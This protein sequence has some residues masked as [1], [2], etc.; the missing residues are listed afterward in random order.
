M[1]LDVWARGL[2]GHAGQ[3]PSLEV[4]A[5]P[6]A[7]RPRAFVVDPDGLYDLDRVG[8]RYEA[9][10]LVEGAPYH[11]VQGRLALRP[12]QRGEYLYDGQKPGYRPDGHAFLADLPPADRTAV[13]EYLK[14]LSSS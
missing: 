6:P 2:F 11:V 13:I 1:L 14:T 4:L 8:V 3:W 5:T 10:T 7:E 9:V 12:L